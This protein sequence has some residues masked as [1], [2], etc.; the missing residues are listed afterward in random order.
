MRGAA[1]RPFLK[2]N[3]PSIKKYSPRWINGRP[4]GRRGGYVPVCVRGLFG[5]LVAL[6]ALVACFSVCRR[7][8]IFLADA[9]EL[10]RN[11][12]LIMVLAGRR[13]SLPC[14]LSQCL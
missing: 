3:P 8:A 10:Q 6:V 11:N 1:G 13:G 5:R 14:A 9:A 12:Y 2:K 4:M 7:R